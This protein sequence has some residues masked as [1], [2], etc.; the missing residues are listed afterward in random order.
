MVN[1]PVS[2]MYVLN[3]KILLMILPN[4]VKP[5]LGTY[6]CVNT[7]SDTNAINLPMPETRGFQKSK[8]K[9]ISVTVQQCSKHIHMD[10][11]SAPGLGPT[12]TPLYLLYHVRSGSRG[13][14]CWPSA[15]PPL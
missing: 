2:R 6:V 5:P 11:P 8:T 9:L 14:W 1:Y 4:V 7:V 10:R 13:S 15:F 3:P 12:S